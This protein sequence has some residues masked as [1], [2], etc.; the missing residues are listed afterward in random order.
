MKKQNDGTEEVKIEETSDLGGNSLPYNKWLK[1]LKK[2]KKLLEDPDPTLDTPILATKHY[3]FSYTAN[4]EDIKGW[5]TGR[6][7]KETTEDVVLTPRIMRLCNYIEKMSSKTIHDKITYSISNRQMTNK[8]RNEISHMKNKIKTIYLSD[9]KDEKCVLALAEERCDPYFLKDYEV[10]LP[11]VNG[12]KVRKKNGWPTDCVGIDT[13]LK[14]AL[15]TSISDVECFTDLITDPKVIEKFENELKL[16]N[17]Q[18]SGFFQTS[19][20]ND[21]TENKITFASIVQAIKES[22]IGK[23]DRE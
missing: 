17:S 15:L 8:D 1:N 2:V 23:G 14:Y 9:E 5:R 22:Y 3:Y 20:V 13:S 12:A 19:E 4:I 6:K 18:K 11:P 16:I 21:Q 10:W 7:F